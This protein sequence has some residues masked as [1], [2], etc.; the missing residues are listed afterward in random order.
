M[1][2][3]LFPFNVSLRR[4]LFLRSNRGQLVKHNPQHVLGIKM[5]YSL[6]KFRPNVSRILQKTSKKAAKMPHDKSHVF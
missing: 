4:I 3:Y 2:M 5:T 1:L 6:S